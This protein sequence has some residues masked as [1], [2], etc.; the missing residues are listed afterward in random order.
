M[1]NKKF[2]GLKRV[3]AENP[4]AVVEAIKAIADKFQ[5]M[6]DNLKVMVENLQGGEEVH[7]EGDAAP[8]EPI[9][10]QEGVTAA[11]QHIANETPDQMEEALNELYGDTDEALA[12]IE[13]LADNLDIPLS[14]SPVEEE[15]EETETEEAPE[16]EE[17]PAA[18]GD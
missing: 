17:E 7:V 5:G 1:S 4:G 18:V 2:A 6:A 14:V 10:G 8:A 12:L 15:G 16:Q 11:V 3:A 13:N 9:P